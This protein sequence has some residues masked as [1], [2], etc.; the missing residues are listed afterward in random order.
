[1]L[2]TRAAGKLIPMSIAN[3]VTGPKRP[4]IVSCYDGSESACM[5]QAVRTGLMPLLGGSSPR[6][7]ISAGK[8]HPELHH[9]NLSIVTG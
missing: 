7:S 1:M 3:V 4:Q 6:A 8:A 9:N 2:I 5:E